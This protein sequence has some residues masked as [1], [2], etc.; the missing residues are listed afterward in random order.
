MKVIKK[1]EN[2]KRNNEDL[3]KQI[4]ML[5]MM[6]ENMNKVNDNK[7]QNEKIN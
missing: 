1:Y 3:A 2:E 7:N 6:L 5:N 4:S